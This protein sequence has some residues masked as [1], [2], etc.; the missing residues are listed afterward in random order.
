MRVRCG[1]GPT[2]VSD[3]RPAR[4]RERAAASSPGSRRQHAAITGMP[5][6]LSTRNRLSSQRG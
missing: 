3:A 6:P 5:L 4:G 1:Q 2:C